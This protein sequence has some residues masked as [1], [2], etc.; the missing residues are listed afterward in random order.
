MTMCYFM[1][2]GSWND[3]SSS[4][5]VTISLVIQHIQRAK[6]YSPYDKIDLSPDQS[7]FNQQISSVQESVE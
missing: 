2:V 7:M 6:F 1:E 5:M 3:V 4:L